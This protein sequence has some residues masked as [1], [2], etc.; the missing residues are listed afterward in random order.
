MTPS[1]PKT[2]PLISVLSLYY[3]WNFTNQDEAEITHIAEFLLDE[4]YESLNNRDGLYSMVQSQIEQ[5][6]PEITA[7]P[8]F[9]LQAY[10]L[11]L[12]EDADQAEADA[13]FNAWFKDV[14]K[15]FGETVTLSP[16]MLTASQAIMAEQDPEVR[17]IQS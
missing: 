2:F 9:T 10:L 12:P 1:A 13:I 3:G 14:K 11:E 8:A 6:F 17:N 5:Q 4:P 7:I 16:L 15:R